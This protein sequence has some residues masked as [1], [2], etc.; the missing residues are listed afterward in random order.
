MPTPT[1]K[2]SGPTKSVTTAELVTRDMWGTGLATPKKKTTGGELS[3]RDKDCNKEVN[4]LRSVV[5]RAIS[6]V[7]AWRIFHTDYRRP[8]HTFAQAFRTARALYFFSTTF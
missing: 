4:G 1:P 5:E 8:L 3:T 2:P 7:K 6:H